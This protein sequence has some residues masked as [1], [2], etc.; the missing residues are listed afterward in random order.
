MADGRDSATLS[1]GE[2]PSLATSTTS[3]R[4][5]D[6]INALAKPE[7]CHRKKLGSE[8]CV[9]PPFNA[10]HLG[11]PATCAAVSVGLYYSQLCACSLV[12]Q[13]LGSPAESPSDPAMSPPSADDTDEIANN[14]NFSTSSG[15]GG[16]PQP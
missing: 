7:T 16:P 6:T 1:E 2:P 14:N 12:L 13:S 8:E 3:E 4:D 9:T 5:S 11:T 15:D 10:A